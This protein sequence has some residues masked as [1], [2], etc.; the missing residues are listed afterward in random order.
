MNPAVPSDSICQRRPGG[1]AYCRSWPGRI[2]V[3]LSCKLRVEIFTH[4]DWP[5]EG[6]ASQGSGEDEADGIAG[7]AE[8]ASQLD[9]IP[10][11]GA[12]HVSRRKISLVRALNPIA[13]LRDVQRVLALAAEELDADVPAAAEVGCRG[14]RCSDRF[15]AALLRKHRIKAVRH[16][17]GVIR[18]HLPRG[19][20]NGGGTGIRRA[21]PATTSAATTTTA[22]QRN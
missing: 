21:A 14:G 19:D 5:R 17:L 3:P 11:D 22:A 10:L 1:Y 13:I 6:I 2:I 16:C 8:L 20:G 15:R 9:L 7:C 4:V 12:E 18:L